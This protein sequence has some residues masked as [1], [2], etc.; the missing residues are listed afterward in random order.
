MSALTAWRVGLALVGGFL[1]GL[2]VYLDHNWQLG[3]GLLGGVVECSGL[4]LVLAASC[5]GALAAANRPK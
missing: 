5:V 3:L 1:F 4:G 2:G